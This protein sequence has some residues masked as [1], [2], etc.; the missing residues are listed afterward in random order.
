M[1]RVSPLS[2][3][4]SRRELG[5][6]LVAL[7]LMLSAARYAHRRPTANMLQSPRSDPPTT[8]QEQTARYAAATG[9]L[10]VG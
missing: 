8:L 2:R 9:T 6:R 1:N 5:T 7:V 3:S 10:L 4:I